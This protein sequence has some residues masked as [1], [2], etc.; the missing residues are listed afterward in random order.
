MSISQ[1]TSL[2]FYVLG[3][4]GKKAVVL[5]LPVAAALFC[6]SIFLCFV[7]FFKTG[8]FGVALAVLELTL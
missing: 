3:L 5:N 8:F 4:L 1:R 7:L 6:L 2:W